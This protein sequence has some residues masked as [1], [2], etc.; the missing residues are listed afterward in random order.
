M[1]GDCHVRFCERLKG[2]TPFD[3][4]G[5]KKKFTQSS[6]RSYAK[7]KGEF[8]MKNIITLIIMFASICYSQTVYEIPFASKCN[9]IELTV[10]NDS[11]IDIE[12]LRVSSIE[13]PSWI[14][15]AEEEI[16]IK[17]LSPQKEGTVAFKFDVE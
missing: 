10:F 7:R 15:Y 14:K 2:E 3:L 17:I 4:L 1:R 6:Q 12:N 9:E 16:E 11:E 5:G 8:E 13:Q